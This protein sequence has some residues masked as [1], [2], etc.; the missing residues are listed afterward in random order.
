MRQAVR[1]P[2][3]GRVVVGR[4]TVRDADG[5]LPVHGDKRRRPRTAAP[6]HAARP[7]VRPLPVLH[8]HLY[9]PRAAAKSAGTWAT[10]R[11]GGWRGGS[12]AIAAAHFLQR[13]LTANPEERA[14]VLELLV[15]PWLADAD[16][17]DPRAYFS[18]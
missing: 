2:R 10:D 6:D 13:A 1:R 17:E 12:V 3:D 14:T 5:H 7:V 4:C 15:H 16:K 11:A 9:V 8:Q 18:G